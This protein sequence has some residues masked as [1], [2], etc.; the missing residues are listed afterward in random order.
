VFEEGEAHDAV[1]CAFVFQE[2][3]VAEGGGAVECAVCAGGVEDFVDT[4]WLSVSF[5]DRGGK[6]WAYKGESS[7]GLNAPP[8]INS[9]VRLFG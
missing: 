8:F 4:D 7:L 5:M 9:R 6:G 3:G 2:R 1:V